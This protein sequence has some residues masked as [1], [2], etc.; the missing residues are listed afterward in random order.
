MNKIKNKCKAIVIALFTIGAPSCN[1]LDVVPDNVATIDYAFQD[2]AAA[3]KFLFTC[4]N[5]IPQQANLEA[6]PAMFG[7][8]EFYTYIGTGQMDRRMLDIVTGKFGHG[9][10]VANYWDGE[11]NGKALYIAIR[12][13]NIFL[14]KIDMPYDILPEERIRWISEVKFLK[15]FYHFYLMRLYGAISIID[16][17]LPIS[18]PADEMHI[19]RD[20]FDEC[21]TYVSNLLDEAAE[22]LPLTIEKEASELG[23]ATKPLALALKAKLLTLSAS[24]LFNGNPDY[25]GI[26]DNRNVSLFNTEYD[27]KKWELAANACKVAIDVAHEAKKQLYVPS[28]I[29]FVL[30]D[31]LKQQFSLR[32]IIW[33]KWNNEIIWGSNS[34]N[35]RAMQE[36]SMPKLEME[37]SINT[38]VKQALSPTLAVVES[39]YTNHGVPI[40]E[41]IDFPYEDRYKIKRTSLKDQWYI[42]NNFEA[43]QL[44]LNRE[45]RFYAALGFDGSVWWGNGKTD[46][47][48]PLYTIAGK[49]KEACGLITTHY[50]STTGYYA[51]KLVSY[52]TI[53]PAGAGTALVVKIAT[54][55]IIRLADL[56]LLYAETL[57]ETKSAPDQDVYEYIDRVRERAGLEGVVS[58]WNK[59]SKYPDK[60]LTKEGMRSIIQQERVIELA[61]E[62]K[63]MY[64]IRRWKKGVETWNGSIKGWNIKGEIAEDY[65][66]LIEVDKMSFMQKNYLWPLKEYNLT[67]NKNLRQNYGW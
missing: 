58:S 8:G 7:G 64:D 13:C 4:Y 22:G 50:Y 66:K 23:R 53:V 56:Y 15:A 31:T 24:P 18:T 17:N 43:V 49:A 57:N 41:D 26:I 3:E 21:V 16:K 30:N 39:Y 48:K 63:K 47:S 35:M 61:M 33:E 67:V 1:Y 54:F 52:E 9:N 12:D 5:Y 51:K 2:R 27:P 62:G 11:S 45:P 34:M 60:P 42:K 10:I 29:P 59:Y 38:N 40:E 14:E 36:Y 28:N 65:Y 6:D 37:W 55:P 20:P 25:K 19:Y 46:Q 44:H 32:Q